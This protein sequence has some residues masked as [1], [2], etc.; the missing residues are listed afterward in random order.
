MEYPL[1]KKLCVF[2]QI[3]Q[4]KLQNILFSI[5]GN[6]KDFVIDS[7]L[8]KTLEHICGATWLR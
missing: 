2:R 7:S 5:P 6:K 8:I 1:K 4:E 3:A